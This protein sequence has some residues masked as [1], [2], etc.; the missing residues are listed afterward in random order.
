MGYQGIFRRREIKYM[1]D[2]EKYSKLM[3]VISVHM[4][5]DTYGKSLICSLHF[6]T[7]DFRLIR[8]SMEK[9]QYKEKLRLRS[10]GIPTDGSLA[11]AEIKKK[12]KG[13]VY[14]R[15][16]M[17][18]YSQALSWLLSECEAPDKSQISREIDYFKDYYTP[19][20]D[21]CALFYDRVAYYSDEDE[22]LRVTF[23]E[24]I[25]YRFADTDLRLGDTGELLTGAGQYLMEIK[26][27]AGMPLWLA[28]ALSANQ[29]FPISY[30][31]YAN[32]YSNFFREKINER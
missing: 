32:A 14:K 11:F 26:I 31:K 9:P 7:P 29:I 21:A 13:I 16:V 8:T 2:S 18:A 12:Y 1:L 6:D 19:L 22:G 20:Y 30:S 10:Y 3:E 15:R 28:R 5:P 23:D 25:R 4:E 24:N 17:L 27:P